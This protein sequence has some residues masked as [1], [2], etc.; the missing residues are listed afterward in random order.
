MAEDKPKREVE[1]HFIPND[2]DGRCM[3]TEN[4]STKLTKGGKLPDGDVMHKYEILLPI[5]ISDEEAH[6][7]QSIEV[8][9]LVRVLVASGKLDEEAADGITTKA[10]LMAA[11]MQP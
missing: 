9:E 7:F 1:I 10:E 11:L 4:F 8:A 2:Y 6:E 5:P 3:G